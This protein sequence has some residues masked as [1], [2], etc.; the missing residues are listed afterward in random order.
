M[1][2]V[3]RAPT[4]SFLSPLAC[5]HEEAA[6][7]EKAGQE[8]VEGEGADGEHVEDLGREKRESFFFLRR[9]RKNDE[10]D[11]IVAPTTRDETNA[12]STLL[13]RPHLSP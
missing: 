4:L 7:D 3:S 8:G 11:S 1:G 12:C 2:R 10:L 13:L 9:F 6:R 5:E